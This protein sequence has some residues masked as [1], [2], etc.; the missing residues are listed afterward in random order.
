MAGQHWETLQSGHRPGDWVLGRHPHRPGDTTPS[1]ALQLQALLASFSCIGAL[2]EAGHLVPLH[3]PGRQLESL[4][5][6][7]ASR[8]ASRRCQF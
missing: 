7:G 1:A 6:L 5:V 8:K 4:P 2:A 3:D